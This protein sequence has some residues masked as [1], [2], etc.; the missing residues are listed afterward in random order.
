MEILKN[1]H[2]IDNIFYNNVYLITEDTVVLIDTGFR[3]NAKR[4][5]TYIKNKTN[6]LDFIILTHYHPDHTGSVNII[7]NYFGITPFI[8]FFDIYHFK[9]I[10]PES[11]RIYKFLDYISLKYQ[12]S[13]RKFQTLQ[14]EYAF[15]VLGGLK[16]IYTPGHTPGSISLYSKTRKTLFTGDSLQVKRGHIRKPNPIFYCNPTLAEK[17][18][19]R[20]LGL[21]FNHLLPS[22]GEYIIDIKKPLKYEKRDKNKG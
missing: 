4:I 19:K 20:L 17:S 2:R 9:K 22:D 21:Q 16:V 12:N 15:P 6:K 13:I 8:H 10:H 1:I 7:A 18:I 5:I 3:L 14:E 11:S